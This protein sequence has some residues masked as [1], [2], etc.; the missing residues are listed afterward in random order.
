MCELPFKSEILIRYIKNISNEQEKQLIEDWLAQDKK[1]TLYLKQLTYFCKRMGEQP[2]LKLDSAVAWEKVAHR[3]SSRCNMKRYSILIAACMLPLIIIGS[4]LYTSNRAEKMI[5]VV[6]HQKMKEVILP[7]QSVVTLYKGASIKYKSEF[8]K[9]ERLIHLNGTAYF[10]IKRDT[11]S[12]FVIS[13]KVNVKVLGTEFLIQEDNNNTDVFVTDGVVEVSKLSKANTIII[14]KGEKVHFDEKSNLLSKDKYN[15]PNLLS[16]MT[17]EFIFTETTLKN[18][19]DQLSYSYNI[20][21]DYS[22][23]KDLKSKV[24]ATFKHMELQDILYEL[25]LAMDLK[26]KVRDNRIVCD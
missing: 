15:N 10:D 20:N 7:D 24:T 25:N 18:V 19:L 23:C 22:N 8:V 1:N 5:E 3:L 13:A 2:T 12:P 14:Y 16:W 11:I 9:E 4:L 17:K 21:V 26:L 6:A